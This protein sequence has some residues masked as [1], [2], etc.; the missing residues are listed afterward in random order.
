M[1]GF[2]GKLMGTILAGLAIFFGSA[3]IAIAIISITFLKR[4]KAK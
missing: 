4:C 2:V 1:H 3:A